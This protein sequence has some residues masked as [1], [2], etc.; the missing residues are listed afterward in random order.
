MTRVSQKPSRLHSVVR[1]LDGTYPR[2]FTR[3]RPRDCLPEDPCFNEICFFLRKP[4]VYL[5]AVSD[6]LNE[7]E[8]GLRRDYKP[9]IYCPRREI[10][11][12]ESHSPISL[13][14]LS[15]RFCLQ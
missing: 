13:W 6:A 15:S 2:S 5:E 12:H 4:S 8:Q 11:C 3:A 14:P 10:S 7:P 9:Q 1:N